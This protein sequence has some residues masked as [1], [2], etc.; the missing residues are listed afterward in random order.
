[1]ILIGRTYGQVRPTLWNWKNKEKHIDN[2][3]RPLDGKADVTSYVNAYHV[4]DKAT[5]IVQETPKVMTIVSWKCPPAGWVKINSD[6]ARKED[7][8]VGC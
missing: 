7:G 2:F 6:G 4:A 1:M 3:K 8:I 5:K